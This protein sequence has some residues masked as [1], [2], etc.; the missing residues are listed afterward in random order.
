MQKPHTSYNLYFLLPFL[1][2][3][4]IGGAIQLLY[5]QEEI[6]KAINGTHNDVLDHLMYYG[7]YVGEGAVISSVLLVLMFLIPSLRNWWYFTAALLSNVIPS[8]LTQVIKRSINAPRPL[9]VF[10]EAGWIHILPDWPR[11]MSNSFPSGHTCGAFTFVTF[12]ALLLWPR[13]KYFG[14]VLFL[15]GLLVAYSR[16]YLAVH[17]FKDVYVGSIIGTVATL[18]IVALMNRYKSLFFKKAQ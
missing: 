5:T 13:Y 14:I 17:F 11:H 12:L 2:W 4:I 15:L 6:F 18:L 1:T 9:N 7:T 16:V 10:N 8:L 3:V